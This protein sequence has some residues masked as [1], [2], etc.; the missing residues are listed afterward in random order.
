MRKSRSHW[1]AE[2]F[3]FGLERVD[4]RDIRLQFFDIALV[5]GTDKSRDY[6]VNNLRCIHELFR[7]FLTVF[8][9]ADALQ[10]GTR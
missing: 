8:D 7:R 5:L 10:P 9:R 6:A 3:D 1:P 2:R 4:G